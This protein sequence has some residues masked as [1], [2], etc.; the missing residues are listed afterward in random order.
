MK[1][2]TL[3]ER[4]VI[5][6]APACFQVIKTQYENDEILKKIPDARVNEIIAEETI[7]QADA[8]IKLLNDCFKCAIKK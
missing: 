1:D 5:A 3:K 8:I 7:Q 4:L 2:L 6:L